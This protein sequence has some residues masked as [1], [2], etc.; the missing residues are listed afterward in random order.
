M[1]VE[2]TEWSEA[3]FG[4]VK[5]G[6]SRRT[7]RVVQSG[8][9]MAANPQG[10]IP[11]QMQSWPAAKAVY[12]LMN[13]PEVTH[14][15]LMQPHW[16]QTR[17]Q[18]SEAEVVI[19]IQD[20]TDLDYTGREVAGLGPIG[21]GRGEGFRL[22][23]AL[24]IQ[25]VPREVMGLMYQWPLIRQAA[26]VPPESSYQRAKRARES[27]LWENA[28]AAIGHAPQG[29]CWVHMGDR[30]SDIFGFFQ[31]CLEHG[32]HFLV[33]AQEDR[34][35]QVGPNETVTHL[36]TFAR[37]LPAQDTKTLT[38]TDDTKHPRDAT[39][40]VGGSALTIQ[41][42]FHSRHLPPIAAWVIRVW[43]VDPPPDVETPLEWILVTSLPTATLAQLHQRIT[44]YELRPIVEDYHQC[45]KTGCHLETRQLK[46]K[47]RL[48][49]LLGILGVVAVR[50][51]QL[52]EWAR[53]DPA[54]LAHAHFPP[55]LVHVVALL[56]GVSPDRLT[57]GHLW[58]CIAQQGGFLG[59]RRD[60]SPGWQTLWQGWLHVQ[61]LVEGVR[62]AVRL[63]P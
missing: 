57:V 61:T 25:P 49:R 59:R 16:E 15:G 2:T 11:R 42:P 21:D 3:T 13:E 51:L 31:A 60:G 40:L 18:A 47:D 29:T 20:T 35:V 38:V 62:L 37:T 12:R 63:P 5:L 14:A 50:L 8:A 30:G 52:R 34:R 54:R 58:H 45:L 43:E 41:P 6:D 48:W 27:Q 22:H 36:K 26:P 24:A 44:W 32:C 56:A 33:R 4:K 9:R 28:V 10:S 23:S 46:T 39:V 19:I 1:I 55:D 17:Q 53:Q 7:R